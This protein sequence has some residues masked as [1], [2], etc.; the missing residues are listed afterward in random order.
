MRIVVTGATGNVG[1][2]LL[3]RLAAEPDIRVHGVS[4][5][6]P[7]PEPPYDVS[8][9][10]LDLSK[11]GAEEP[12]ADVLRGADAVVHL[13]WKIQPSHDEAELYRTNVAGSDRV[14]RATRKAGVPHL[15]HMSSVG[16]YSPAVK[17]HTV[18]ES[19]PTDGMSKSYYSRHKAA[20]ERQL[21]RIERDSPGLTVTRMRPALILQPDAAAEIKRY[22]LGPLVPSALFR[23]DLPVLPLPRTMVLQFVH[24]DDVA[25]ALA[26]VVQRKL[27]GAFNLASDPVITPQVL[28]EVMRTRHVPLPPTVLRGL[29]RVTWLLRL[30]PTSH[31]WVDLALT[32]PLLDAAK[33]RDELGWAPRH[34][35]RDVLRELLDGLGR[36]EGVSA[37]PPLKP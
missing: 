25:D 10:P 34:N 14:F 18:D 3:R 6:P 19:W 12:L 36:R 37:S 20:V 2:A 1:T 15:V 11:S 8:W 9:T 26:V 29:A 22:F 13:A 35:A 33:A 16:A 4:R 28:A 27:P 5:R 30:Q 24:A 17:D 7:A 21:D 23:V 32:V 31:G